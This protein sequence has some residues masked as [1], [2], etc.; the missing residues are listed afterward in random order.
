MRGFHMFD[1]PTSAMW[2]QLRA[3]KPVHDEALT[4]TT[5]GILQDGQELLYGID[6]RSD[7][8]LLIP[9]DGSPT[10]DKPAD[11]QGL[12]IRHRII[13]GEVHY[14]DLAASAAHERLF[15]P[16]ASEILNAVTVQ[17]RNPWKAANTIIRAWQSAW[18]PTTPEMSKTVQVGL[19]GE[20]LT[21][22][23]I[24][25]PALGPE[26]IH[27]WSGP[28]AE[29]HDFVGNKI[30]LEVKT[31][32]KSRHEHEISRIDQLSTP[33]DRK[34]IVV[35][36]LLEESIAGAESVATKMDDI[37]DLIRSNAAASDAFMAKMIR[38]GWSDELRRS[39][40]LLR[41]HL[42]GS[43]IYEVNKRFPCLPAGFVPSEGVV[44][45]RYTIDLTNIPFLG[46]D[47]AIEAIRDDSFQHD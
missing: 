6:R 29:R 4:T 2:S 21:L 18:R 5:A 42:R 31:T 44:A 16:L 23:K 32:R 34:L 40:Q 9:V 13:E 30:H 24:M 39:G 25:I 36:L 22:E 15:S 19:F 38:V 7:L 14:L 33:A 47:D 12:R 28:E 17:G 1:G 26:S 37:L 35:S 27:L 10:G 45:I 20:L 43:H 41:F 46:V 11:L 8:H 3:N